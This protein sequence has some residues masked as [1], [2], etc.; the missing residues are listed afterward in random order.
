MLHILFIFSSLASALPVSGRHRDVC[1]F[2]LF[3]E[4]SVSPFSFSLACGSLNFVTFLF[5]GPFSGAASLSFRRA[6]SGQ[7]GSSNCHLH[8]CTNPVC[9]QR[10]GEIYMKTPSNYLSAGIVSSGSVTHGQPAGAKPDL[11]PRVSS[12]GC[13]WTNGLL[14]SKV[15][16]DTDRP[17]HSDSDLSPNSEELLH[18]CVHL[19]L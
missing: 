7:T 4:P 11:S 9:T 8:G 12:P 10:A 16:L 2:V 14:S 17:T 1:F 6:E 15:V 13:S 18:T 19:L 3:S 5:S